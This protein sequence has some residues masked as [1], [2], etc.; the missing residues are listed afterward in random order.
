MMVETR[1]ADPD[2]IGDVLKAEAMEAARLR[3]ALS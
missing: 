2:L 1:F 3:E